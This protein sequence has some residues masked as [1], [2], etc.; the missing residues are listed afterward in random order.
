MILLTDSVSN[1]HC[2]QPM[3]EPC[4]LR[5]KHA[6]RRTKQELQ[7]QAYQKISYR[8]KSTTRVADIKHVT[9]SYKEISALKGKC[10]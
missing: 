5:N 10:I 8:N 7:F 6:S 4:S 9:W 1:G 3:M 2:K